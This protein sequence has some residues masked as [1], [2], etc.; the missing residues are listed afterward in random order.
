LT[1]TSRLREYRHRD[2]TVKVTYRDYTYTN[3]NFV[4]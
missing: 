4:W 3:T 1:D 2:S